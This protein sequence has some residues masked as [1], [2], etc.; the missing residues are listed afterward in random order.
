MEQK[1]IGKPARRKISKNGLQILLEALGLASYPKSTDVSDAV[2]VSIDF[3]HTQNLRNGLYRKESQTGL[4]ILDPGELVGKEP[5][6]LI[7]TIN[8]TTGSPHYISKSNDKF[9]FGTSQ[10]IEVTNILGSIESFLP[11]DRPIVLVGHG[12]Y[13]EVGILM[14]LGFE[15]S[16]RI[17]GIIDTFDV[18]GE[19]FGVWRKGLKDLLLSLEIPF[20]KL[21]NA[22]NDAHFTLRAALLLASRGC[23]EQDHATLSILK[24]IATIPL[25]YPP[26]PYGKRRDPAQAKKAAKLEAKKLEYMR[27][28]EIGSRT[29]EQKNEIRAERAARRKTG[30]EG[31]LLWG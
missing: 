8:L 1:S 13:A 5:S 17:V 7:S 23:A 14:A 10:A 28:L 6:E 2:L 24:E 22:G 25:S 12:V 16:A 29:T 18:A 21:H 4:A 31:R 27:K 20:H 26:F 15:F 3:E 11:K 9:V 19:V 30:G